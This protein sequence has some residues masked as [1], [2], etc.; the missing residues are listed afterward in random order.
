MCKKSTKT[1]KAK[2]REIR[3]PHLLQRGNFFWQSTSASISNSSNGLSRFFKLPGFDGWSFFLEGLV[4]LLDF[5]KKIYLHTYIYSSPGKL[6]QMHS[7]L[8]SWIWYWTVCPLCPGLMDFR[9]WWIEPHDNL[10]NG[11]PDR[12]CYGSFR[13]YWMIYRG[14]RF[15]CGRVVRLLHPPP[16]SPVSIVS[17]FLSLPVCRR[18]SL[19]TGEGGGGGGGAVTHHREK[20][21]PTINHSI[22]S[23]LIGSTQ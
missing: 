6:V 9:A 4:K 22:L 18:S 21:W 19:L 3:A 5:I 15:L 17:L 13:E 2:I 12:I 20:A 1:D 8:N 7:D 10:S 23:G 11:N 16:H 14:P